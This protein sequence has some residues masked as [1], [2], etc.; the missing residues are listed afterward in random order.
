MSRKSTRIM[1]VVGSI[2]LLLVGSHTNAQTGYPLVEEFDSSAGFTQTHPDVY[3]SG[4]QVHWQVN[5]QP[6]GLQRYVYRSIPSFSGDLRLIVRG[7]IDRWGHPNCNI[8]AGI[9]DGL[10]LSYS[11]PNG[12]SIDFG[13]TGG[14]CGPIHPTLPPG[15]FVGARGVSGWDY[16]EGPGAC[17]YWGNWLRIDFGTPYTAELTISGGTATLSVPGSSHG[18]ATGTAT[19]SGSYNTLFVGLT[20]DGQSGACAGKIDYIIVEPANQPPVCSGAYPSIDFLWPPEHQ[21]ESVNI[22][23]VT[24]PDGDPINITITSIS[25]DELTNGLGDGD[26]SPDGQGIGTDTAQIRAETA[27]EMGTCRRTDRELAR[28]QPRYAPRDLALAT[29]GSITSASPPVMTMVVLA[30]EKWWLAYQRARVRRAKLWTMVRFM[31]QP[32]RN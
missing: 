23:G 31:T 21:L 6:L 18:V 4:G 13:W 27:W 28:T 30:Q 16:G 8:W 11:P 17:N 29:A 25:Q 20:G 26:M 15:A 5:R 10:P 12:Y 19:Y 22:L 3:I 2:I 7:Q 24:D 14:G 32:S 1:F 9:G